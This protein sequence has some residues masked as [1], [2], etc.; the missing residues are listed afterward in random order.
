MLHKLDILLPPIP[1]EAVVKRL[2]INIVKIHFS[3]YAGSVDPTSS[4]AAIIT[5][6]GSDALVRQRFTIAHELGHLLFDKLT[7]QHRDSFFG[8][9]KTKEELRA[10]EFAAALLIPL[11][12]LEPIATSR[13]RTTEQ[14]AELFQVS[15][16]AMTHQL[17]QIVSF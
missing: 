9:L 12:M 14:L 11:W 13:R 10:N 7:I 4:P 1:I 6:R 17:R 5:V 15:A 2:G 3:Q 8:N 16:S